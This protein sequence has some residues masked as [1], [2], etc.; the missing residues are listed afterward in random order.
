[1]ELKFTKFSSFGSD[2][3]TIDNRE[4]QHDAV[5]SDGSRMSL[6]C[7][8][9]VG[10]GA[11]GVIELAGDGQVRFY[12]SSGDPASYGGTSAACAFA[13]ADSL[14][15]FDDENRF[16]LSHNRNLFTGIRLR[17]NT[18]TCEYQVPFADINQ[19]NILE[20]N[21]GHRVLAGCPH[22][23][24]IVDDVEKIDVVGEGARICAEDEH[25]LF[26]G[27]NV[28]FV[29]RREGADGLLRVRTFCRSSAEELRACGS[30]AVSAAVV[31]EILRSREPSSLQRLKDDDNERKRQMKIRYLG[32]T[33]EV[34]FN[35]SRQGIIS[36]VR[37]ILPALRVFC[38][39]M[40]LN[41]SST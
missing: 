12:G 3:I 38:G 27:V 35:A 26:G 24:K 29:E 11:G 32:G 37:L 4:G 15:L 31:K 22:L 39:K 7:D 17:S 40:R 5:F 21:Q 19:E 20:V 16:T 33:I 34:A 10:I 13:F 23:V 36:D 25:A 1:M 6:L 14:G 8:R 30:G 9:H 28:D 2:Y 18:G 41:V